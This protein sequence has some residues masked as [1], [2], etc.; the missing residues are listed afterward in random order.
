M[1]NDENKKD[2][3]IK[4]K[5]CNDSFMCVSLFLSMDRN[6]WLEIILDPFF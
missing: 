3:M 2:K 1:I 6:D 4:D 5:K